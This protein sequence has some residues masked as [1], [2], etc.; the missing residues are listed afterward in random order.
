MERA[1]AWLLSGPPLDGVPYRPSL[2]L[3]AG[4]SGAVVP[5]LGVGDLVLASEVC[6]AN[7]AAW[8]ATWPT[9][10]SPHRRG[11]LLT[12]P[13]ILGAPA[14]KRRLGERSGAVAVDMET[15][16]VARLCTAAGVPFGCLR[17]ISDDVDTPLSEALLDVLRDGRVRP[18]RLA[19]AVLRRPSLMAELLRLAAHTRKAAKRL[20]EGL[21]GLLASYSRI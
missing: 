18:A 12:V 20:A 7:G 5:G 17:V 19:A 3:S 1:L 15:A 2:V 4:F 6:D 21:D 10:D 11:R 9:G 13:H 16:V 8:P 14:E